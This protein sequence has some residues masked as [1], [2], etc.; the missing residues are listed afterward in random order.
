MPYGVKHGLKTPGQYSFSDLL[1]LGLAGSAGI[2][3]ALVT[4]YQQQGEASAIYTINQWVVSAASL[5]GLGDIPLYV[6]ILGLVGLG[7]GSIFYF[8]PI[9]RQGAF[10]QGFG[11]LAVIMTMTPA[12]L[13]GGLEPVRDDLPGLEMLP[14]EAVE[15]NAGFEG[16]IVPASY[17]PGDARVFTVQA[18]RAARYDV[19]LV[20]N[21]TGGIPADI[22]SLIRRGNIRGRLHN[23]DTN[24]TYNLFRTAGGSI[25]RQGDKLY[26]RAG[27]PARSENATLWVRVECSNNRIEQQSAQVTLGEPLVWQIDMQPSSTPLWMQRLQQS[28]WF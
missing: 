5:L 12:D 15:A 10:A 25:R 21:F 3:S 26:I 13:A 28:Y 8:Q 20:I 24:S 7:A 6:V 9:T 17:T 2:I 1:G 27:V 19:T 16:G 18:N 22:D 14:P 4:D 23:A 11:L